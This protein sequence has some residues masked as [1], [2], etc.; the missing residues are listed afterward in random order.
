[1]MRTVAPGAARADVVVLGGGLAGLAAALA[2]GRSGRRVVLIERDGRTD[3]GSAD[4]LFE[5]WDRPGIAH[6]RQPHNFLGLPRQTL[7]DRRWSGGA[8][9]VFSTDTQR[10]QI[11]APESR[12]ERRRD[13]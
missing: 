10:G 12:A 13:P 3:D 9:A 6:F 11:R 2:F 8:S 7:L 4:E 5:R 1:M